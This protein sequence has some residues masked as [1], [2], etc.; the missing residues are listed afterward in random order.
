VWVG[1]G[2]TAGRDRSGAVAVVKELVWWDWCRWSS[3]GSDLQGRWDDQYGDLSCFFRSRSRPRCQWIGY[4]HATHIQWRVG[5]SSWPGSHCVCQYGQSTGLVETVQHARPAISHDAL[6]VTTP[7]PIPNFRRVSQPSFGLLFAYPLG[8]E[9]PSNRIRGQY[10]FGITQGWRRGGLNDTS[11]DHSFER[12]I[13]S[14]V[15]RSVGPSSFDPRE[16][17]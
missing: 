13:P 15:F 14:V 9:Y 1:W 7:N 6:S 16:Y 4:T 11:F 5:T 8:V 12:A 10:Q 3:Q 17:P 2:D